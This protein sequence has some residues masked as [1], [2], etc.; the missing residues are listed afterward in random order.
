MCYYL[1]GDRTIGSRHKSERF[2]TATVSRSIVMEICEKELIR[3]ENILQIE[4]MQISL[5]KAANTF[6]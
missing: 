1:V 3:D 6:W 5:F 2:E 4:I